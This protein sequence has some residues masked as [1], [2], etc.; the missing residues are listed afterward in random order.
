MHFGIRAGGDQLSVVKTLRADL[1]GKRRG[2]AALRPRS[3]DL[4]L[5]TGDAFARVYEAGAVGP[6]PYLV[7]EYVPGS[8][9]RKLMT[10]LEKRGARLFVRD[11]TVLA[12]GILAGVEELHG[13]R[14]KSG[15]WLDI[16]HRDLSPS[17]LIVTRERRVRLIDLGVGRSSLQEVKTQT[18]EIVGSPGFLS[19]EQVLAGAIDQRSDQFSCAAI[20]WS[21]SPASA[22]SRAG[23]SHPCWLTPSRARTARCVSCGRPSRRR[24]TTCLQED[25]QETPPTASPIGELRHALAPIFATLDP[26]RKGTLP[27][28]EVFEPTHTDAQ[29][30]R[31]PPVRKD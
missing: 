15:A 10:R 16:I 26:R 12:D 24:S 30:A 22:S 7:M 25:L 28:P 4:L 23:T 19:P 20:I 5:L 6:V 21:S 9:L 27:F 29:L 13:T 18:G 14:S 2:E 11:A 1:V 3:E 17:N 8:L 31:S